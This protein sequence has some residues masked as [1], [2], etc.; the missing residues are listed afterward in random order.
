M[1]AGDARD[2]QPI[3]FIKICTG[4]LNIKCL[5]SIDIIKGRRHP[6]RSNFVQDLLYF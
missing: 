4:R 6:C 5:R 3:H 1:S 2:L